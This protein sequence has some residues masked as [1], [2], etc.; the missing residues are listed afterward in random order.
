M[1]ALKH[2]ILITDDD[3]FLLEMYALKFTE[4][5]FEVDTAFSAAEALTKIEQG[6]EPNICLVDVIMPIMDG[7]QMV[8]ELKKRNMHQKA[9]II[10]L[11]NLGQKEDIERALAL[12]VDG[13][14][15]KA[16]ATPSEVVSKVID[17]ANNKRV[18]LNHEQRL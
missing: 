6:F 9:T 13:Y 14:I 2:R 17:I 7:F 16:T 18:T 15:V 11:S 5:G 1:T 12:G 8:E 3:K 4:D 10:I